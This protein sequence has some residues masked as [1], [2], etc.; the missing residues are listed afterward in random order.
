MGHQDEFKTLLDLGIISPEEYEREKTKRAAA[1][2]APPAPAAP[3][4][5]S[6]GQTADQVMGVLGQ[7][8][9]IVDLGAKKIY[10]YPALKI[11]FNDGRVADVH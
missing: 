1:T 6:L 10:I 3:T 7:P 2:A 4:T 5:I 8:T 11:T 9:N